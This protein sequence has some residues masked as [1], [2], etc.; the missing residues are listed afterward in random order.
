M[1]EAPLKNLFRLLWKWRVFLMLT[2]LSFS[3]VQAKTVEDYRKE[4]EQ[5]LCEA[6][7]IQKARADAGRIR[8][9][10][11]KARRDHKEQEKKDLIEQVKQQLR[12]SGEQKIGKLQEEWRWI[13][14]Q[15]SLFDRINASY[16]KQLN[17]LRTR[18]SEWIARL[19]GYRDS[20]KTHRERLR[21]SLQVLQTTSKLEEL[22]LAK[23]NLDQLRTGELAKQS[24]WTKELSAIEADLKKSHGQ[25]LLSLQS[26]QAFLKKY[27]ISG[28]NLPQETLQKLQQALQYAKMRGDYF[29]EKG[30]QGIQQIEKRMEACVLSQV[31][32]RMSLIEKKEL[33]T[34]LGLAFETSVRQW[35]SRYTQVT[36]KSAMKVG[37]CQH[38]KPFFSLFQEVLTYQALC[39]D[40]DQLSRSNSPYNTGCQLLAG[41]LHEA[42]DFF[43]GGARDQINLT[44]SLAR[45]GI[46]E[47]LQTEVDELAEGLER[48]TLIQSIQAHD[49]LLKKWNDSLSEA[50]E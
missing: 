22:L 24:K 29:S 32:H 46:P 37:C 13:K 42:N 25:Y 35:M 21:S 31:E 3:P 6:D 36:E 30:K 23:E 7:R 15:K 4:V 47:R 41:T 14:H 28:L 26:L 2:S 48:R 44:L 39:R 18:T 19:E 8:A 33:D 17:T 1:R 12:G 40:L 38:L 34:V 10:G 9:E 5:V 45:S 43:E 50:G 20:E 16:V 11:A 49:D 27:G